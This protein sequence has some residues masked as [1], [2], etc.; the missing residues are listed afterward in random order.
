VAQRRLEGAGDW[1]WRLRRGFAVEATGK[2]YGDWEW[3]VKTRGTKS[4]SSFTTGEL[5]E[6]AQ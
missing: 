6:Y 3:R 5:A 4:R 2:G 1:E